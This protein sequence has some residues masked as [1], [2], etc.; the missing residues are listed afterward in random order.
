MS[1][2]LSNLKQLFLQY[3]EII[4]ISVTDLWVSLLPVTPN[5]IP[6]DFA[7]APPEIL[8]HER[9]FVL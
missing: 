1:P 7:K 2:G 3:L 8:K 4:L 6:I 9:N 5:N